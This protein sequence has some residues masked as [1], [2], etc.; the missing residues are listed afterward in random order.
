MAQN[1][2]LG[3]G[4]SS[5]IP[6]KK[7]TQ[8]NEDSSQEKGGLPKQ[9][10]KSGNIGEKKYNT[11]NVE[12]L[13]SKKV[14]KRDEV[15]KANQSG[16]SKISIEEVIANPYQPR[17]NFDK[18]KLAELSDSIKSHGIIQ[19]LVVTKVEDGFELIAGERRLQAA[20]IAGIKEVPVVVKNVDKKEKLELAIIENIQ[21]HDLSSME[22]AKAYHKL[23]EEF[24]MSQEDVAEKM[25][26][27]RSLVANKI[28]LLS[29]PIDAMKALNEEKITEGHAKAILSLEDKDKQSVLLDLI[30]KNQLTVRQA[31]RKAKEST[32]SPHTRKTSIDPEIKE[33]EE[34]FSSNLGT[35][36]KIKRVGGE[37]GRVIIDYY[38]KEELNRLIR[39]IGS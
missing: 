13:A 6:Q 4:L 28:R 7:P 20:K 1:Y 14:A 30:I 37:G 35:K 17:I 27:S 39:S 19:P 26:K 32:I 10:D 11:F 5:L 12:D 33:L 23:T 31:E 36:V 24:D 2:G 16:V 29:L 15:D 3:R 38:S 8:Q 34:K 18:E 25:G 22:E 9:G 21:R